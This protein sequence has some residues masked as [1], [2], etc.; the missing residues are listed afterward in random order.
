MPQGA[1]V[2][3]TALAV[4]KLEA[5]TARLRQRLL[6][7]IGQDYFRHVL[8]AVGDRPMTARGGGPTGPAVGTFTFPNPGEVAI[9]EVLPSEQGVYG[10]EQVSLLWGTRRC[11]FPKPVE[12]DFA[13]ST[14]NAGR[15]LDGQL[16]GPDIDVLRAA[17][18]DVKQRPRGLRRC[19]RGDRPPPPRSSSRCSAHPQTPIVSVGS[20]SAGPTSS[21]RT[22]RGASAAAPT[23]SSVM[24]R[25][26]A[27]ATA[28]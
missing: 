7:K 22:T 15:E 5:G 25:K 27:S 16:A 23:P 8:A 12:V 1:P 14:M 17:P 26:I 19:L 20:S 13:L 6:Q 11:R 28:P 2:E 9:V 21:T 18:A 24:M 3:A 4:A 10:S